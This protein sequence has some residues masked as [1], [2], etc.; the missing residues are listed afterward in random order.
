MKVQAAGPWTLA[1]G[2]E[3]HSGHRV[4]TDAGA[5]REFAAS[6]AEGLAAHA[7]EVASR[8]GAR[9]AIQLDEPTLPAVLAGTVPTPSGY[10]TSTR[11]R[12]RRSSSC[13]AR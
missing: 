6:L 2:V 7:A 3:L 5:L 12:T 1:A 13:S 9:V 4:L 11:Y 8:T 10:G